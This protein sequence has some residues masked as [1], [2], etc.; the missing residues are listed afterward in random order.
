MKSSHITSALVIISVI[1]LCLIGCGPKQSTDQARIASL[2]DLPQADVDKL[3][4]VPN[5]HVLATSQ[6][7]RRSSPSPATTPPPPC[8]ADAR[9]IDYLAQVSYPITTCHSAAISGE[10]IAGYYVDRQ[11]PTSKV[12][13]SKLPPELQNLPG[14]SPDTTAVNQWWVCRTDKGPWQGYLVEQ[15]ICTLTC[16][17]LYSLVLTNVPYPVSFPWDTS[18]SNHHFDPDF[19]FVGQL[20]YLG[21]TDQGSCHQPPPPPPAH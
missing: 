1:G 9:E 7:Q 21:T 15:H 12:A 13:N 8:E 18:L 16:E 19:Q 17:T 5:T 20:V 11:G 6:A 10:A 14:I 4:L 2:P 3:K